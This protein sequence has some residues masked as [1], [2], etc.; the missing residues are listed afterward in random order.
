[1]NDSGHKHLIHD[2]KSWLQGTNLLCPVIGGGCVDSGAEEGAT[3]GAAGA[4]DGA[5]KG[6]RA[7][8]GNQIL[9]QISRTSFNLQNTASSHDL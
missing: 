9:I 8:A 1:M 7:G 4:R 5:E 3:A 6:A 2:Q